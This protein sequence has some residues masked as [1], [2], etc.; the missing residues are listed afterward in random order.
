MLG[1]RVQRGGPE[2]RTGVSDGQGS[3]QG[4]GTSRTAG[5]WLDAEKSFQARRQ[6]QDSTSVLRELSGEGA[7]AVSDGCSEHKS[8]G[9]WAGQPSQ[10]A[11][12]LGGPLTG[13]KRPT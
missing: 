5:I 4:A 11:Q 13:M 1:S 2:C 3:L 12:G 7:A 9:R 10:G 6:S 8:R